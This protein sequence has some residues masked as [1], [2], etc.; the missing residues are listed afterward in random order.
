MAQIKITIPDKIYKQLKEDAKKYYRTLGAEIAFVA[1]QYF[2]N[3]TPRYIP[4]PIPTPT[5]IPTEPYKI[6]ADATTPPTLTVEPDNEWYKKTKKYYKT[7]YGENSPEWR[8]LLNLAAHP[9][10]KQFMK[11]PHA[12]EVKYAITEDTNTPLSLYQYE[13]ILDYLGGRDPDARNI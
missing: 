6:T 9:N 11:T 10:V 4:T 1:E 7:L 2:T 3:P 8:E 13:E 12:T 5:S